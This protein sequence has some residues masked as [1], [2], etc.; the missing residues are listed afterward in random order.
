MKIKVGDTV[1]GRNARMV[2]S[3]IDGDGDLWGISVSDNPETMNEE[4]LESSR[5]QYYHNKKLDT[6]FTNNMGKPILCIL[7]HNIKEVIPKEITETKL[8]SLLYG[9]EEET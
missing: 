9:T 7:R 8:G 5:D 4:W 6:F 3:A 1:V 2:V